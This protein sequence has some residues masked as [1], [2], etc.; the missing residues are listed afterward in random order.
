MER[1]K[2]ILLDV[3]REAG[4]HTEV[5][6]TTACIAAMMRAHLPLR[7]VLVREVDWEHGWVDTLALGMAEEA[8]PDMMRTPFTP[9]HLPELRAWCEGGCIARK[10]AG[11]T[12][13]EPENALI[14][15]SLSGNAMAGPLKSAGGRLGALVLEAVHGTEFSPTHREM[16]EILL[17][18]I[19]SALDHDHR[20]REIAALREAAEADKRSLLNRLG[21]KSIGDVIVGSESGL[22]LVMER[23]ELVGRSDV[24]VLILGETGTGKE[25]VARAI[26]LRS[27]RAQG[28]VLRVNCG[29]IPPELLDAQLFG[30]ERGAFT[31]AVEANAGWFE[32]ANGGTLFLD[33]I[34]ELTLAAQV[35][36]LR[37]LQD[38][39]LERIG[40]HRTIHV[41]VR[42][43]AATHRDLPAMIADGG[44]REDL[45]YRL[46]VFPI[47]LP[48]L[49]DRKE[50]IPALARHFA[51]KAA[52]RFG[53]APQM[54]AAHDIELLMAYHWP[55]NI[56]ELG[57]VIDR[58]AILGDGHGLEVA[59]AL[60]LMEGVATPAARNPVLS[61]APAE[62]QPLLSLDE[63]V[64]GHIKCA[65]RQTRGR[66][67]GPFGA[68]AVLK[69]NPHTLR[70]KMRKLGVD[71]KQFRH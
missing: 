66:I 2:K 62:A 38:G 48:P 28:P 61:P 12:L 60:G 50:D 36:L 23:V 44:F 7:Q 64:R 18:P 47:F 37:V 45:W 11:E 58:A 51:G 16:L 68:A 8:A 30:Y 55:G 19:A 4:R 67:D 40:G 1:F 31:G 70:A 59:K 9:E 71:W 26:H 32:R 25:V 17:E 35:R 15:S 5:G 21:R 6:E 54:P 46:A 65:L 13:P 43:V 63:A 22:R 34:G 10:G 39:C 69:I 20:L 29:A 57:T 33:E 49:R 52:L 42:V 53:L 24:P 14:P 3:W 27:N 41:D 56:R